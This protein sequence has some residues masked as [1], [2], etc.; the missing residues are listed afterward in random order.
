M[1]LDRRNFSSNC[2]S[3]VLDFSSFLL[4]APTVVNF[5]FGRNYNLPKVRRSMSFLNDI[6]E[7]KTK[8]HQLCSLIPI[9]SQGK[10]TLTYFYHVTTTKTPTSSDPN[11]CITYK[12]YAEGHHRKV[13][14]K[15]EASWEPL[16][17]AKTQASDVFRENGIEDVLASHVWHPGVHGCIVRREIFLGCAIMSYE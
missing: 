16:S 8:A 7:D 4:H 3:K 11:P 14:Q 6:D 17:A 5:S 1:P 13:W 15:V 12:V 10:S 9:R 2:W